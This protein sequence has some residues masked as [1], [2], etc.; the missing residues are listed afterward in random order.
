M[1]TISGIPRITVTYADAIQHSN[2]RPSSL[3]MQ[4]IMPSTVPMPSETSTRSTVSFTP[5]KSS[6]RFR[7][8]TVVSKWKCIEAPRRLTRNPRRELEPA[9]EPRD[10]QI[11]QQI[12]ETDGAHDLDRLERVIADLR[13]DRHQLADLKESQQRAA[14]Q[15]R[16]CEV[17][18]RGNHDLERLRQDHLEPERPRRQAQCTCRLPLSAGNGLNARARDVGQICARLQRERD[19]AAF[20]RGRRDAGEDGQ[21]EV[22]P[23]ELH[24]QRR[25]APQLDVRNDQPAQRADRQLQQDRDD[26]ADAQAYRQRRRR[27]AERHRRATRERLPILDED[28]EV[29]RRD[30]LPVDRVEHRVHQ[31]DADDERDRAR[32][33][34]AT[35]RTAEHVLVVRAQHRHLRLDI[36]LSVISFNFPERS[37][38]LKTT[39]R[40][41]WKWY[42]PR[43]SM[44]ANGVG[45]RSL[46]PIG[47]SFRLGFCFMKIRLP[48]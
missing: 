44:N 20:E 31:R 5:A 26:D 25:V 24:D 36:H 10:E 22:H 7:T 11:E 33:I 38:S 35:T 32:A 23:E 6:G 14:V 9:G 16:E 30:E 37:R 4:A 3:P 19:E 34:D 43:G 2:P 21:P 15:E 39:S 29:E 48:T 42:S 8:M 45:S 28:V 18:E 12:D 17:R 40:Y 47:R 1:T 46:S 13:S 27:D 41:C